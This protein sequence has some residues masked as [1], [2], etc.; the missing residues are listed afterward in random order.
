MRSLA[1]YLKQ[2]KKESV[3]A[4]LFKL[5][6]VVFDLLVP[7][8]VAQMIDVGAVS[9]TPLDVYKRQVWFG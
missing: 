3:L 6:E 7:L 1:V 4:P 2:Y 8:V 5:L 9:Y